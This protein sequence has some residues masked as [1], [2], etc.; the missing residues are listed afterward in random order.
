MSASE[1]KEQFQ[2][3]KEG[4]KAIRDKNSTARQAA[5]QGNQVIINEINEINEKIARIQ[6]L[7][8]RSNELDSALK[9]KEDELENLK[10]EKDEL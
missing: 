4:L 5:E 10:K 3:A 8:S 2:I 7:V 9:A 1:I 6:E